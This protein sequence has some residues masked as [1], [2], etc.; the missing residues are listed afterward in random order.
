MIKIKIP[1]VSSTADDAPHILEGGDT[2]INL[3]KNHMEIVYQA[4]QTKMDEKYNIPTKENIDS[5]IHIR[6]S[7]IEVVEL[8]WH[9]DIELYV[10]YIMSGSSV[11][12]IP[13]PS[14]EFGQ[15]LIKEFIKWAWK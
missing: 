4:V 11:T 6:R 1:T 5:N 10:I 12:N 14:K 7:A 3:E 13:V 9:D 2:T 15:S 8:D